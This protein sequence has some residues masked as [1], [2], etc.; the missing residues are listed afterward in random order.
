METG[1]K[2]IIG[3]VVVVTLG[4]VVGAVAGVTVVMPKMMEEMHKPEACAE[5]CHEMVPYYDSLQESA[6]EGVDCHECHKPHGPEIFMV[7]GHALHHAE[8]MVVG[9]TEGKSSEEIFEEMAEEIEEK[10]PASP[11]REICEECHKP[12]GGEGE[13]RAAS[14]Q[15]ADPEISCFKC[16]SSILHEAHP[17]GEYSAY[18]SP[19][20]GEFSCVACHNDHD[21]NVKEETCGTCHPPEKHP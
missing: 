5:N 14:E 6:H 2:V 17:I 10:P 9:M 18:E 1:E 8:G 4:V 3:L 11:K 15:I 12:G 7:M 19:D 20:Y 21:V 16:H 13:A